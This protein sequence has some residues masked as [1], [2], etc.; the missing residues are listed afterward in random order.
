MPE[1][2]TAPSVSSRLHRAH[3]RARCWCCNSV[4]MLLMPQHWATFKW[5]F[6]LT[7][8]PLPPSS[9]PRGKLLNVKNRTG[10]PV[11][12]VSDAAWQRLWWEEVAAEVKDVFFFFKTGRPQAAVGRRWHKTSEYESRKSNHDM[13]GERTALLA[14]PRM[15]N[16]IKKLRD[17]LRL[18]VIEHSAQKKWT[19]FFFLSYCCYS[20]HTR[21]RPLW[22]HEN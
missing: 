21:W 1:L 6:L 8:L 19:H 22:R 13:C 11:S 17:V 16:E 10:S 2:Y 5:S 18:T 20:K 4:G 14:L 9:S 15:R 7:Y 3:V 12:E